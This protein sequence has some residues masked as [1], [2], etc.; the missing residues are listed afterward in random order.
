M[1]PLASPARVRRGFTLVELAGAILV[2]AI[3]ASIAVTGFRVFVDR[4]EE[5]SID[6]T[7][8]SVED[9]AIGLAATGSPADHLDVAIAEAPADLPGTVDL[10][11]LDGDSGPD[12]AT[13][14]NRL[15]YVDNER[16]VC[17]TLI[18]LD[19]GA[20]GPIFDADCDDPDREPI[21]PAGVASPPPAPATGLV[22]P[23]QPSGLVTDD[24]VELTWGDP[25]NTGQ[26]S[27]RVWY[28]DAGS[29]DLWNV[30]G[31]AGTNQYV[32]TGLPV[33]VS[34][35]GVEFAVSA[36]TAARESDRS[37][38]SVAYTGTPPA[39][40]PPSGLQLLASPAS[41]E[42]RWTPSTGAGVTHSVLW[43]GDG[44]CTPSTCVPATVIEV[45]RIGQPGGSHT[46]TGVKPGDTYT[47]WLTAVGPDP[48]DPGAGERSSI[49]SSPV[50]ATADATGGP[51]RPTGLAWAQEGN[52]QAR[53]TWDEPGDVQTGD[54]Y[55]IVRDGTQVATVPSGT[56]TW[57][58]P[59]PLGHN[60]PY[61]YT[62][63]TVRGAETSG[64]AG[65][66]E[67][68]LTDNEPPAPPTSVTVQSGSNGYP[69]LRWRRSV[70]SDV[71]RYEIW[72]MSVDP[73]PSRSGWHP[74]A[75]LTAAAAEW[76]D[77][78]P[79]ENE[80]VRYRIRAVDADGLA[81][82]WVEA[83]PVAAP[84]QTGPEPPE[85]ILA[86]GVQDAIAIGW[87]PSDFAPND[88]DGYTVQRLRSEF[89]DATVDATFDIAG[90]QPPYACDASQVANPPDTS[91]FPVEDDY[92][93]CF[94][95]D[96]GDWGTEYFY[97]VRA[98]DA[99][100]NFSAWVGLSAATQ[101]DT[102][103]PQPPT[104][105]QVEELPGR[106]RLTWNLSTSNDVEEYV[107]EAE[108]AGY[109]G[110]AQTVSRTTSTVTIQLDNVPTYTITVTAVDKA[111]NTAE[112]T[113]TANVYAQD[114]LP[115]DNLTAIGLVDDP[116]DSTGDDGIRIEWDHS[117]PASEVH[118]R[119]Y[120]LYR[121]NDFLVQV[122]GTSHTDTTAVYGS[123]YAYRIETVDGFGRTSV[124]VGPAIASPGDTT[125]PSPP[126]NLTFSGIQ[127][128]R[129]T[130]RVAGQ[131]PSPDVVRYRLVV[132]RN[133]SGQ[134]VAEREVTG[135][136]AATITG[137][138]PGDTYTVVAYAIDR[139]NNSSTGYSEQVTTTDGCALP[140]C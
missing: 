126:T 85:S 79:L 122:T 55:R 50:S 46:D 129:F 7:L 127:P 8:R 65:P 45:A 72:R 22:P 52:D 105:L 70:S 116:D 113:S 19:D 115:P 93:V 3:I 5:R 48:V 132:I 104:N 12:P 123:S 68:V 34:G 118:Q 98:Y 67:A 96:T 37:A 124:N 77:T 43:R 110:V 84:D 76:T 121:D 42:A 97:R 62:V 29:S 58:D 10:Y 39:L 54:T 30:S 74:V 83:G 69:L 92:P 119:A 61:R 11:A 107:I 133:D 112:A 91:G 103:D 99:A 6:V 1:V 125:P 136:A 51:G 86:G 64:V 16:F 9:T 24:Q 14:W 38:P 57:V 82:P 2:G 15:V 139:G 128:D 88:L 59:G 36:F 60:T 44:T 25:G 137:L 94:V 27:Y 75:T 111:G 33:D 131:S 108:A 101:I 63:Q 4:T 78:D 35:P 20:Q 100:G 135:T 21:I 90:S 120:R 17:R 71:S 66:V 18:V 56:T 49:T 40:L 117:Q 95:D 23:G 89:D 28:R 140:P 31:V 13:M 53:L 47:Y 73:D 138:Q 26:L 81:S 41:I 109:D 130:V 134:T 87:D 102:I 114:L 106:A 80:P 32:H